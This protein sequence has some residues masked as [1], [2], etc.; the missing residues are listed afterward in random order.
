M[1]NGRLGVPDDIA[2]AV[3]YLASDASS[4]VNGSEIVIDGG[5]TGGR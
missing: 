2:S 4:Y 1:P 5:L 3:V